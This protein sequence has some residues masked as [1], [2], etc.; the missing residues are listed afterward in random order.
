[1]RARQPEI[2]GG[3][4]V[5]L[6][7]VPMRAVGGTVNPRHRPHRSPRQ[8]SLSGFGADGAD[9]FAPLSH[10]GEKRKLLFFSATHPPT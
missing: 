6:P 8:C 7:P 4:G 10:G 3:G 9:E 2:T 1:M 5:V